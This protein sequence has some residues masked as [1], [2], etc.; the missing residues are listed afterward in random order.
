[1]LSPYEGFSE[2]RYAEFERVIR[3]KYADWLA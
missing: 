2:A 3:A 1:L